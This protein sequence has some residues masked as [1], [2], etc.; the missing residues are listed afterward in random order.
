MNKLQELHK[1]IQSMSLEDLNKN[2][3]GTTIVNKITNILGI[4]LLLFTIYFP[5]PIVIIGVCILIYILG[6]F[7]V[8]LDLI[9]NMVSTQIELR[10]LDK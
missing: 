3:A 7:S 5:M 9:S 2:L 6:H 4:L 1:N 8:A 10:K